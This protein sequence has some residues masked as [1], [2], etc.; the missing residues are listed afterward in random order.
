MDFWILLEGSGFCRVA[1]G[2]TG[3]QRVLMGRLGSCWQCVADLGSCLEIRVEAVRALM[4]N[5][6]DCVVEEPLAVS[7]LTNVALV[8]AA[9]SGHWQGA[10]G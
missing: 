2:P 1:S 10:R 5:A 4:G 7:G 9:V 3:W 6:Y 8:W